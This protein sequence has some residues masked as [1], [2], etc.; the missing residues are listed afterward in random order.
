MLIQREFQRYYEECEVCWTFEGVI[1]PGKLE[2]LYE[3]LEEFVQVTKKEEKVLNYEFWI[4]AEKTTV[5]VHER[6]V[7]CDGAM[8]SCAQCGVSASSISR[9]YGDSAFPYSWKHEPRG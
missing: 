3:L 9:M 5:Y 1:K 8:G 4:N 6:F 7:D 2:D